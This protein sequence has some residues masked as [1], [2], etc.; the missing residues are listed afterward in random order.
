MVQQLGN[1]PIIRNYDRTYEGLSWVRTES[2]Y[3]WPSRW[4]GHEEDV[5]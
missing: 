5:E 3:E 1:R 2:E 4:I